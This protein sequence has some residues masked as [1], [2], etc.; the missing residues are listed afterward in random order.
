MIN[1]KK[2]ISTNTHCY[3]LLLPWINRS[4]HVKGWGAF[5]N[6]YESLVS[7]KMRLSNTS[8]MNEVFQDIFTNL[9]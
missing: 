4:T 8:T 9:K 3:D 6:F 7:S 1:F 2:I 5:L